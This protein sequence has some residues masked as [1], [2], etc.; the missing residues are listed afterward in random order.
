MAAIPLSLDH[1]AREPREKARLALE[2]PGEAD[3]VVC[4]PQAPTACYVKSRLQPTRAIG[5]AYLKYKDF[6]VEGGRA[7][8]R[9]IRPP[10]TPPYISR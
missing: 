7:R 6:N 5:D 10:Y 4:K 2:H 3:V 1:N 8:G 9:Y